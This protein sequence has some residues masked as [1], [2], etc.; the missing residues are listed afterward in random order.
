MNKIVSVNKANEIR[1]K[2]QVHKGAFLVVE[3]RD[4]RLFMQSFTSPVGCKIEV[5]GGRGNVL[6]IIKVLEEENL[7]GIIGLVDSD[8]NRIDTPQISAPNMVMPEHHDLETM[9]LCSPALNRVLAEFGSHNK[10]QGFEEEVLDALIKRALPIGLLRLFSH[11][12]GLGLRFDGLNYSKCI[13]QST[14]QISISGLINEVKNRSQRQNLPFE[15]LENGMQD[16]AN[17]H[18]DP[19]EVCNGSD[20]VEILLVGL[21]GKLGNLKDSR[22]DGAA[23]RTALRLAYSEQDFLTSTLRSAIWSWQTQTNGFQ[24]LRE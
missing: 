11:R 24:V 17:A 1:L 2:R 5:G 18:N 6:E 12:S 19:L 21:K 22:A 10:L 14:F 8:F 7:P 23:L 9:L 3:G 16:M 4:D 20:L 15:Q 13:K